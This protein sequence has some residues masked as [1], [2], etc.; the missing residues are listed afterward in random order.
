MKIK[1][2]TYRWTREGTMQLI[3]FI[4]TFAPRLILLAH[5]KEI[6]LEKDG[7]SFTAS[8]I[9]LQGKLKRIVASHS[10][11]IG[12]MY[13]KGNKNILSFK[14]KEEVA[15]GARPKH[16]HNKE[17]VISEMIE[18]KLVAHWDEVYID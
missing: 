13:R 18:D 5:I 7:A 2:E 15:C 16:L 10:D 17:I 1:V 8:D 9:D 14:T 3:E 4:K 12:Y 11:A 6:Y